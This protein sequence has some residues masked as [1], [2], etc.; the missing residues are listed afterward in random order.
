MLGTEVAVEAV[1]GVAVVAVAV[2]VLDEPQAATPSENAPS[3]ANVVVVLRRPRRL[4]TGLNIGLMSL[5]SWCSRVG[6]PKRTID[7]MY[8]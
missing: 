3:N 5:S 7:T 8:T 2:E 4:L 6:R 1:E